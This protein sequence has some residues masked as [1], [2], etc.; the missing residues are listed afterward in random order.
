MPR[1][2]PLGRHGSALAARL[3]ALD[4]P[5]TFAALGTGLTLPGSPAKGSDAPASALPAD[6]LGDA[7]RAPGFVRLP[8]VVPTARAADLA[9]AVDALAAH[10][11]PP[12]FVLVF[13]EAWAAFDAL[14]ER[15][16]RALGPVEP[17]ADAWAF[18]VEPGGS[19]WPPH[20]GLAEPVT[21]PDG[22][23][24]L[25][26]TW[27]ALT[28]ARHD[29]SCMWFVAKADDPA[30]QGGLDAAPPAA[31]PAS[32]RAVEV[33]AGDAVVWDA[34]VLHAGGA[35]RA[36]ATRA[37]ASLSFTVRRP[38][39]PSRFS[40]LVTPRTLRARLDLVAANV[41]TYGALD[42]I[43]EDV[44]AWA[45]LTAALASRGGGLTG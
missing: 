6:G 7:L 36:D 24:T 39:G 32:A 1:A 11:L 23:P 31:L 14:V 8:G 2:L 43:S 13:D 5:A 42:A 25:I 27:L 29:E 40:A 19:G 34:N 33:E 45:T 35:H 21:G 41:V 17:L 37:R 15:L 4:D 18:R 9:E 12:T 30:L 20:R 44:R 10:G 28:P 26:D 3:R 22:L 38:G 16:A